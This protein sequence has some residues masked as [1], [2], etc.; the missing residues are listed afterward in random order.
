[1]VV[2]WIQGVYVFVWCMRYLWEDT[3][4]VWGEYV[5]VRV[6]VWGFGEICGWGVRGCRVSLGIF[7]GGVGMRGCGVC[8]GV[9]GG[10]VGP[11]VTH[12]AMAHSLHC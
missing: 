2:G 9:G 3:G 11:L 6:C 7:V 5:C 4:F 10:G 1:M 8:G 12:P